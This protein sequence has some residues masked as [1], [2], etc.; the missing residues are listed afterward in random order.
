MIKCAACGIDNRDTVRL[1]VKCSLRLPGTILT[2]RA[3]D[4]EPS[5]VK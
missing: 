2:K 1:C 4:Q 5:Y 3:T